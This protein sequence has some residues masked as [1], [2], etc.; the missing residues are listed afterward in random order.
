MNDCC[1]EWLKK[2]EP[3]RPKEG[4]FVETRTCPS[5]KTVHQILFVGEVLEGPPGEEQP[6]VCAA[7]ASL[8]N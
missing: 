7:L 3:L 6:I 1:N 4:R 2:V 8:P 5:C